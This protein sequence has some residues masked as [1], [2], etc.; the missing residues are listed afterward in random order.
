LKRKAIFLLYRVLQALASPLILVYLLGRVMRDRHYLP[1]LGQRFG[2]LPPSWQQTAP[3]A[4]WFHAVSV[5]EVLAAVPL[6]QE[7]RQRSPRTPIFLSTSTLAGRET[8]G[9]RLAALTDGIFYAP[10]DFVWCERRVLRRVH[11]RRFAA[12]FAPVLSLSD[13]ILVQSDEM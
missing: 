2:S 9:K 10:L 6:I 13:A 12:F 4:V 1:T 3:A 5:G 8:A 11:Y 7:L